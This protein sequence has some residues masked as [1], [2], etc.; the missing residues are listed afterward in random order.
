MPFAFD[1]TEVRNCRCSKCNWIEP[2]PTEHNLRLFAQEFATHRV[3][4][5][6]TTLQNNNAI[7][8]SS[9]FESK[10]CARKSTA[11]GNN[12]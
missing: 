7:A 12:R 2:A 10:S 5:T 8:I 4:G 1:E 9:E 6:A 3:A 11:N